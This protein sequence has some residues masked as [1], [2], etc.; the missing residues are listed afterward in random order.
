MMK[1]ATAMVLGLVAS[2][3]AFAADEKPQTTTS[4]T[5]TTTERRA[6]GEG[7]KTTIETRTESDGAAGKTTRDE[8]LTV[9]K[10]VKP[11][12]NTETKKDVKTS[13]KS[14]ASPRTHKTEVEEKTVRDAQG[15]VI[16]YEKNVK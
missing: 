8:R 11:S 13:H 14:P 9:E 4:T 7:A 10:R 16:G 6:N 1:I 5:T 3:R 12:G 15:N 2:G